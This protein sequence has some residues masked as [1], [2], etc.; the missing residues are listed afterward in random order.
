MVLRLTIKIMKKFE[1][2][3]LTINASDLGRTS[4][5]TELNTKFQDWGEQGWDL[6]KM[7]P[8]NQG[9]YFSHGANTKAF[10]VVFKREKQASSNES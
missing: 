8:L 10:L 9:S 5:Q 1:Y 3:I 2:K 6:I 7:E 4:F